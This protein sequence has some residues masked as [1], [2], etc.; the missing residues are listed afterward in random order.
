VGEKNVIKSCKV[1][2]VVAVSGVKRLREM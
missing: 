2:G 1:V